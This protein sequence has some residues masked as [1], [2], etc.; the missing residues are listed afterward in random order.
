MSKHVID[1]QNK[2]SSNSRTTE[3]PQGRLY[4]AWPREQWTQKDWNSL[5]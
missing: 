2:A 1:Y 5:D 3:N 4:A